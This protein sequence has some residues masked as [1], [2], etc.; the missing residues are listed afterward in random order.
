M[1]IDP[2]RINSTLFSMPMYGDGASLGDEILAI[3]LFE[4]LIP[5]GNYLH[6]SWKRDTFRSNSHIKEPPFVA[7]YASVPVNRIIVQPAINDSD[8]NVCEI[9]SDENDSFESDDDALFEDCDVKPINILNDDENNTRVYPLNDIRYGI[10]EEDIEM[11]LRLVEPDKVMGKSVELAVCEPSELV[12]KLGIQIQHGEGESEIE[13]IFEA[14]DPSRLENVYIPIMTSLVNRNK[15]VLVQNAGNREHNELIVALDPS[16]HEINITIDDFSC[17]ENRVKLIPLIRE[18]ILDDFIVNL[19]IQ[20]ERPTGVDDYNIQSIY[21]EICDGID[22]PVGLKEELK[23]ELN[24]EQPCFRLE[25]QKV[26]NR[27]A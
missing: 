17:I 7:D 15:T 8:T 25:P 10:G 19:D 27:A 2:L 24:D 6:G 4:D 16:K 13:M 1:K 14:G 21:G 3:P 22:I 26:G 12:D 20:Y 9:D 11:I 5:G 18:F 23:P